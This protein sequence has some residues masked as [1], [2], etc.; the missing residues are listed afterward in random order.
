LDE[1][2]VAPPGAS[3]ALN[4][5]QSA[6]ENLLPYLIEVT[7]LH[8]GRQRFASLQ[9]VTNSPATPKFELPRDL[10]A[11]RDHL[12]GSVLRLKQAILKSAHTGSDLFVDFDEPRRALQDYIDTAESFKAG[13]GSPFLSSV[14]GQVSAEPTEKKSSLEYIDLLR[15]IDCILTEID[16]IHLS[17]ASKS[18]LPPSDSELDGDL[19]CARAVLDQLVDM[20]IWSIADY[21]VGVIDGYRGWITQEQ[22][23]SLLE[24]C[25]SA[26][27]QMIHL[28]KL[29]NSGSN[30]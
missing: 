7:Q 19:I 13:G 2:S 22:V 9:D 11:R 12:L 10:D 16:A 14:K 24:P 27:N 23:R 6:S 15:S 29:M 8:A 5:L 1:P 18:D 28:A 17:E 4:L 25:S 26:I 20:I 3:N 30:S 21:E